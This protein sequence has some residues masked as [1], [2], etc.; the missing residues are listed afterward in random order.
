MH[1]HDDSYFQY[2]LVGLIVHAGSANSGHYISFI[3]Q[4]DTGKWLQ[5]NDTTVGEFSPSDIPEVAFGGAILALV[6]C[7][8]L[9]RRISSCH[10]LG[11]HQKGARKEEE[12]S[13]EERIHAIL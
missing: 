1:K 5:F 2:E 6:R 13:R 7:F 8:K 10:V 11:P 9:L 3:K 12:T 4:R